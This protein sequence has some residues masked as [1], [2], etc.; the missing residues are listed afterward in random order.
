MS[1]HPVST[2]NREIRN[3]Q[4]MMEA[5]LRTTTTGV[6]SAASSITSASTAAAS[7]GFCAT[8]SA[9]MSSVI[10]GIRGCLAKLPLIGGLFETSPASTAGPASSTGVDPRIAA[11]ANLITVIRSIFRQTPAATSGATT[12]PAAPLPPGVDLVNLARDQF[13]G[14]QTA[15]AKWEAFAVVLNADNSSAPLAKQF[16]DALTPA[17]Q[18]AFRGEMYRVNGGSTFNGH[19]H[20]E[21]FGDFMVHHEILHATAKTAAANL[22]AAPATV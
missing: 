3:S 22:Q 18:D 17:Q 4:M 14:I 1:I 8:I 20:R 9:W 15:S 19:D 16:Y 6:S 12:P 5:N 10:E 13:N 21:G 11:D 7:G 2:G